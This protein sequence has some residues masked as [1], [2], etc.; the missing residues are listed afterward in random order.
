[1]DFHFVLL[2]ARKDL[3]R[4]L[5]DPV[6]LLLWV[7]LP[8]VMALLIGAVS[9]GGARPRG[10][11]LVADLDD[12]LVS[13][14]VAAAFAQGELGKMFD[15]ETVEIDAGRARIHDGDGSALIVVPLGFGEAVLLEQ[16]AA[17][18]VV[19]NPARQILPKIAEETLG[20]G[21]DA[22]FYAQRIV[23][24]RLRGGITK[25]VEGPPAGQ[26]VQ[27]DAFVAGFSVEINDTLER[28]AR[29]LDPLVLDVEAEVVPVKDEPAGPRG[30]FA[31]LFF[32]SMLFLSLLF[33]GQGMSEDL[34]R[35]RALG[36]LRRCRSSPGGVAA[37]L[38][39][40]ALSATVIMAAVAA[41]GIAF[42]LLRFH[43]SWSSAPLALAWITL[44]GA[45]LFALM[46]LIQ[47]HA[48]TQRGG[49]LVTNLVL[50]PLSMIGGSFFPFE[51]MPAWMQAIGKRTPNGFG[52]EEFKR[53]LF[54]E[55]VFAHVALGALGLAAVTLLLLAWTARR[56]RSAFNA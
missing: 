56:L 28:L 10:R 1:M 22:V 54:G 47:T 20:A 25:L 36:T 31:L 33:M 42:G 7:G 39:G 6:A 40:K 14:A 21:V 38:L 4:R 3:L 44:C 23:G 50:F 18:E 46:A 41:C 11:L 35:E 8:L 16:R 43:L 5:R 30:N 12:S 26:R 32:P 17:I 53:I 45:F 48:S 19:K 29:Y 52:L 51:A 34:W 2:S 13:R 15:V 9:G 37:L 55:A 24:D 27:P 49:H